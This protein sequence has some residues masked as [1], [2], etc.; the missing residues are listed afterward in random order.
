MLLVLSRPA[1]VCKNLAGQARPASALHL[2]ES[3]DLPISLVY[4]GKW[5]KSCEISML[6]QLIQHAIVFFFLLFGKRR[7]LGD[8]AYWHEGLL[9][10]I[11]SHIRP[12]ADHKSELTLLGYS[13]LC[14]ISALDHPSKCLHA[15]CWCH[16]T[17]W[18]RWPWPLFFPSIMFCLL[19]SFSL[20]LQWWACNMYFGERLVRETCSLIEWVY[21]SNGHLDQL[22]TPCGS[23]FIAQYRNFTARK[24]ENEVK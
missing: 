2:H 1:R 24:I 13:S 5:S 8:R 9:Q 19:F 14:R 17:V 16:V 12:A 20:T 3:P 7:N 21:I 15:C 11:A 22:V 23:K 18:S 6:L 10:S 4:E